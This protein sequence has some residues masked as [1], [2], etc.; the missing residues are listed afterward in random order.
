L[1][2]YRKELKLGNTNKKEKILKEQKI[3]KYEKDYL[4][5]FEKIKSY[6]T[7][8]T[9]NIKWVQP[10]NKKESCKIYVGYGKKDP[11]ID[12]SFKIYWDGKCKNG[13]AHGLGREFNIADLTNMWQIAIYRKGQP[14]KYAVINDLLHENIIEG[15]ITYKQSNYQVRRNVIE[16]SQKIY[17]DYKSGYFT[18]YKTPTMYMETSPSWG[19]SATLFKEYPNFKY[20]FKDSTN[21]LD[22][23]LDF[24]FTLVGTSN[25]LEHG[26]AFLKM[27]NDNIK[28]YVFNNGKVINNEFETSKE[29]LSDICLRKG[30]TW[31]FDN[32]KVICGDGSYPK[33]NKSS[34]E[35]LLVKYKLKANNIVEEI[36]S[37][38]NKALI[39]QK[40]ALLIKKQYIRRICKKSVKIDFMDNEEYKEICNSQYEKDLFTKVT[41]QLE[42]IQKEKIAKLKQQRFNRQQ[43]QQEQYRQQQL[44][45]EKQKLAEQQRHNVQQQKNYSSQQL[46]NS[47]NR[48]NQQL[49]DMT[50]KTHN[51]NVFHY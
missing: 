7:N 46:Q 39:A 34:L 14:R 29:T 37:A 45:I 25:N 9:M 49:R 8:D 51:V 13:Y 48:L 3:A 15:E 33:E 40:Q 43:K 20:R 11:T 28:S 32:G 30:Q 2:E 26:W 50:P 1:Q 38:N 19:N 22:T 12:E 4:N 47:F 41:K 5:E 21:A 17:L 24:E 18:N 42:Q 6:F 23:K 10:K 36:K 31:R 27:K 44:T 35:N 16:Q